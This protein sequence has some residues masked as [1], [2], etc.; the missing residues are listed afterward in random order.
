MKIVE[1]TGDSI[2]KLI[3]RPHTSSASYKLEIRSK[4]TN[5]VTT[6]DITPTANENYYNVD[7]TDA[8]KSTAK[9]VDG[10]YYEITVYDA[11]NL[12]TRETLFCTSQTINQTTNDIYNANEGLY[13]E[14]ISEN[15][16]IILE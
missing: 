9:L 8:N 14:V 16:Y 5:V 10:N 15:K 2:L 6:L 4:S 13:K 7:L 11:T 12:L 1:P 3:F